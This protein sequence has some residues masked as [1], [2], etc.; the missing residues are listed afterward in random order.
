MNDAHD[1]KDS[2]G[3]ALAGLT[4]WDGPTPALSTIVLADAERGFAGRSG[5]A[6]LARRPFG[7]AWKASVGIA[8]VLVLMGIAATLLTPARV[9]PSVS[10]RRSVPAGEALSYGR[11]DADPP[12]TAGVVLGKTVAGLGESERATGQERRM[13]TAFAPSEPPRPPSAVEP[14]DRVLIRKATV[15]LK[16]A[17][18]RAVFLKLGMLVSAAGGEYVEASSLT[19]QETSLSGSITLRVAASRLSDVLNQIRGLAIVTSETAGGDDVT[20]QAVDLE[21]RLRN[22]Q[23]VEAELLDLVGK[24]QDAPL[25]DI[26]ELRESLSRVRGSIE[27]LVAQRDR[28]SKLASLATVLV[29]VRQDSAP[30]QREPQTGWEQLSKGMESAW[31]SGVRG[32]I[33]SAAFLVRVAVGGLIWWIIVALV[34][35]VVYRIVK[36]ASRAAA[37]EPAPTE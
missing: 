11:V 37:A 19:G 21:A 20:A 1:I 35:A 22:E 13:G 4:R 26:L 16:S 30:V 28:L 32:L 17:D 8:A 31:N 14:S 18:V 15:E 2:L 12:P 5:I 25:K 34:G 23:R 36:G 9:L 7:R 24:R 29:I 3:E 33:E 6:S 27:Q 10:A